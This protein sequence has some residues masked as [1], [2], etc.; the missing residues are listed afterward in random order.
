VV[1]I[2]RV[3]IVGRTGL[4][5][6]ARESRGERKWGMVIVLLEVEFVLF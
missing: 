1:E 4:E 5:K 2:K 6:E 3:E